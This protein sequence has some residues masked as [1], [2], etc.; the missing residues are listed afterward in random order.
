M[1]TGLNHHGA[2]NSNYRLPMTYI[3]PLILFFL[4]VAL[5][6]QATPVLPGTFGSSVPL[7][8]SGD[9]QSWP[10]ETMYEH[11]NGEAELLKRY[12]ALGV[13]YALY[14]GAGDTVLS[15]DIVDLDVPE[16]AFGLL[17]LY[18]GC[19]GSPEEIA[20]TLVFMGTYTSY[21]RRGGLFIRVDV[22]ADDG[23]SLT[24]EF[25]EMISTTLPAPAP[26]PPVLAV[27]QDAAR[28]PCEVGYH[29]E[30]VDYDLEAGPGYT[31]TGPD[32]Q[33]CFAR[34]FSGKEEALSFVSSLKGKGVKD[35][36]V[37]GKSVAWS[38][39]SSAETGTYLKKVLEKISEVIK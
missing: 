7:K 9:L 13:S 29:P 25:F 1:E 19:D 6:A 28:K 2:N 27:F 26:L 23:A 33:P 36:T 20:G 10:P 17:A 4:L 12:G 14:E 32:G 5:P 11:V 34:L 21:A 22:D 38:K 30:D 37:K 8:M 16:N 31:W 35:V 18:T 3:R 24:R 39:E 15:V